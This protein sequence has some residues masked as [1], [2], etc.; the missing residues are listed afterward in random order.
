MIRKRKLTL[1]FQCSLGRCWW[2]KQTGNWI[3]FFF[4]KGQYCTVGGLLS[5][6]YLMLHVAFFEE[7]LPQEESPS[8]NDGRR[9]IFFLLRMQPLIFNYQ[10]DTFAFIGKVVSQKYFAKISVL[11]LGRERK[12]EREMQNSKSQNVK[13]LALLSQID[14]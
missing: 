7:V 13:I 6:V 11:I 9:W 14:K 3:F 2:H 8:L 5:L 4:G 10:G 12:R 1:K